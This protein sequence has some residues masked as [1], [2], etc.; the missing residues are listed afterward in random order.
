MPQAD[1]NP[2]PY[3]VIHQFMPHI[4]EMLGHFQDPVVV[5]PSAG[6]GRIVNSIVQQLQPVSQTS[7]FMGV[8]LHN[9]PE[10]PQPILSFPR[11]DFLRWEP[12][13]EVD[14]CITNP[15]F[16]IAREFV[17]HAWEFLSDEGAIVYLL[18][19]GFLATGKRCRDFWPRFRPA[20]VYILPH[21]PSFRRGGGSDNSEYAWYVW[22]RN[23]QGPTTMSW[24]P[25]LTKKERQ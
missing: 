25:N 13:L 2:T 24:L 18:R 9:Q 14:M 12:P 21:R 11:T 6:D 23:H 19:L 15:P 8:E 7:M 3:W 5:D 10:Y 20:H 17:E 22:K 16:S 4:L 1:Y